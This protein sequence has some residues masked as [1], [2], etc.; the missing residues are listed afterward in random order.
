[1]KAMR[2]T[3]SDVVVDLLSRNH[4]V[5]EH[6]RMGLINYHALAAR[7]KPT[8][9][10]ITQRDVNVNTIVVIIKRFS[11]AQSKLGLPPTM[12][13]LRD[14]KMTLSS[15]VV[16]VTLVPKREDFIKEL[17]RLVELSTGLVERPLIF[18][19]V[20]SI[21]IIVDAN[22]YGKLKASLKGKY[23]LKPRMNTAKVTIHLS[24]EAEKSPGIAAYITDLLYRNGIN[25]VDAFLGYE[26]IILILDES[27]G[28]P[29][30]TILKEA[31]S[32][33]PK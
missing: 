23:P 8:V 14:S 25:M 17:K 30:Y 7:I 3:I 29:A 19:L 27:D 15:G 11:D 21:K 9:D 2:P 20:S 6:L 31:T 24:D 18:P 32:E 28:P 33:G 12:S 4:P 10:R 1:M 13:I 22:D 26:D 16:D 5:Y